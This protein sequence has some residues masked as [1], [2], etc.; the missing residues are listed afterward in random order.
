[1]SSLASKRD[2]SSAISGEHPHV[3][4]VVVV[5]GVVLS[6]VVPL[7]RQEATRHLRRRVPL[8]LEERLPAWSMRGE[9][10]FC[11]QNIGPEGGVGRRCRWCVDTSGDPGGVSIRVAFRVVCRRDR[12]GWSAQERGD[13]AG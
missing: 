6:A 4:D 5:H 8:N 2:F 7:S 1:M 13:G 3:V 11:E 10:R 9:S 12:M